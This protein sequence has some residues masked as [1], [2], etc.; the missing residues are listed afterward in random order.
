MRVDHK[1]I[2]DLPSPFSRHGPAGTNGQRKPSQ[3]GGRRTEEQVQHCGFRRDAQG[4]K[5]PAQQLGRMSGLGPTIPRK[6]HKGL[7]GRVNS[8]ATGIHFKPKA[9]TIPFQTEQHRVHRWPGDHHQ[10][11]LPQVAPHTAGRQH[12]G[13]HHHGAKHG[14]FR[15]RLTHQLDRYGNPKTARSGQQQNSSRQRRRPISFQ[16]HLH[17]SLPRAQG[18]PGPGASTR[19]AKATTAPWKKR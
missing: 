3:W 6:P 12:M 11:P 18:H 16:D 9:S 17:F 1:P 7:G 4:L 14:L 13:L 15:F 10:G 19:S 8:L 2:H 5:E